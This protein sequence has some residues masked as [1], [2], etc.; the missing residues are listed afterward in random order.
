[1][2]SETIYGYPV[3]E[4]SESELEFFKSNSNTPG[5]AA[6][7]GSIVISPNAKL[8]PEQRKGL[9]MNEASRLY[10]RENKLIPD[11]DVT[12]EQITFFSKTPYAN[13]KEAMRQTIVGRILS[14]D[15][16]VG[17]ITPLQ[18]QYARWIYEQMRRRQ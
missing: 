10:M 12:P 9:L 1:M 2:P 11:F 15:Q 7:D 18:E 4:P 8:T 17:R 6:D 13:N 16:S 14:N 3:R 5:Y